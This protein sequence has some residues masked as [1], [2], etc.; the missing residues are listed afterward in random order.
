MGPW[1]KLTVKTVGFDLFDAD[2]KID[3]LVIWFIFSKYL[4]LNE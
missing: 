2:N 4:K 3:M 1:P